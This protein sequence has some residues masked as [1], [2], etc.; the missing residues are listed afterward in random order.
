VE[1]RLLSTEQFIACNVNDLLRFIN[2][3]KDFDLSLAH[4]EE[5]DT[6]LHACD[7]AD[8]N[9]AAFKQTQKQR[10]YCQLGCHQGLY[11]VKDDQGNVMQTSIAYA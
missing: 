4:Q 6:L 8:S 10:G 1:H 5:Q 3:G 9:C 2:R 11:H 7:V